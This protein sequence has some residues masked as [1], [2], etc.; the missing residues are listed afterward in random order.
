MGSNRFVLLLNMAKRSK[1]FSCSQYTIIFKL[2]DTLAL[3]LNA[4]IPIV[5]PT[6]QFLMSPF[7]QHATNIRVNTYL[8]GG[9]LRH[10]SGGREY[11][12]KTF[13]VMKACRLHQNF[14]SVYC[15]L[16]QF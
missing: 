1:L 5:Q 10:G 4:E 12:Y 3:F 2:K 14:K 7:L 8:L 11:L 15:I 16:S 9:F 6:I 13:V